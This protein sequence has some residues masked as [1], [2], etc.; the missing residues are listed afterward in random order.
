V[1]FGIVMLL[2]PVAPVGPVIV[3]DTVVVALGWYDV[4]MTLDIW[5]LVTFPL[6]AR[7]TD[8]PLSIVACTVVAEGVEVGD[9]AAV[10]VA[11][12]SGVCVGVGVDIVVGVGVDVGVEVGVSVGA[13]V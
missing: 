3:K 9:G 7:S 4:I 5:E 1:G 6:I 11:V 8:A 10:G 13:G 12:V 2:K